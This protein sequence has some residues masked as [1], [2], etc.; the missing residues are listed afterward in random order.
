MRIDGMRAP[1]VKVQSVFR[2]AGAA[3]L[4]ALIWLAVTPS[5]LL[6]WGPAT[7]IAIGEAVLASLHL[8]PPSVRAILER[9][10]TAYL[11]GSVAADISFAKKYAP[12][13]RHCHHWHVGEEILKSA[14]SEALAA[15]GFGYLSHLAADTIAHNIFVPR[16]LL[17]T[18]T[19]EAL[20]HTYWEHRMDVHLGD[21]VGRRARRVVLAHDHSEADRL[22]DEV[23]SRT[24]FSFQ[25][26]RRIFRGMVRF[27]EDVRWRQVFGEVL[28][29]SRFD[30][31]LTLR[32]TY[33]RLS[34]RYVMDYLNRGDES[35]A[36]QLDPIGDLNLKLA[37]RVR[38][39]GL[40]DGGLESTAVLNEWADTFF[41]LPGAPTLYLPQGR[42]LVVPDLPAFTEPEEPR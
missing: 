28:K 5:E 30:L 6:A 11:Y 8:L 14:D 33:V 39:R 20:G 17:L 3:L 10:R 23:L 21:R 22:M 2:F 42:S 24:L 31:P 13:G 38:K 36:R 35:A 1:A 15:V 16:Q 18:S 4:W 32:E 27:Q 19:T 34:Y 26:N 37:K 12:V 7:H 25:T 29:R 9:Y 40:S 41:P